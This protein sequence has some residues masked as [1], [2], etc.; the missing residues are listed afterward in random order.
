MLPPNSVVYAGAVGVDDLAEQLRAANQKEGV[1][2]AYF[3]KKGERTGACAV[4]IT[5]HHR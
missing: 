2:S 5:G 3:V 1:E 4:I